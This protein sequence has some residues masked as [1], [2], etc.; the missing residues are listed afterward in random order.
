ASLLI[1]FLFHSY[2]TIDPYLKLATNEMTLSLQMAEG[3]ELEQAIQA[4]KA[5]EQ[6]LR[7]ISEVRDLYTVATKHE[8]TFYLL[9]QDKFTQKRSRTE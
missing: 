1:A 9:L 6:K 3:S 7:K 4:A 2:V 5:A 8:L